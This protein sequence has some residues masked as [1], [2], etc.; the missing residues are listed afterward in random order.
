[1][2]LIVFLNLLLNIK[3]LRKKN[4]FDKFTDDELEA[5]LKKRRNSSNDPNKYL[6]WICC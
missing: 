6:F 4:K 5:E 1:M 2:L 3:M